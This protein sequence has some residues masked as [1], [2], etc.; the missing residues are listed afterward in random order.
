[1]ERVK[2]GNVFAAE[3]YIDKGVPYIRLKYNDKHRT[4]I[5]MQECD[6]VK[7]YGKLC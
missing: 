6:F 4:E 3:R 7:V 2:I 1:M 5:I